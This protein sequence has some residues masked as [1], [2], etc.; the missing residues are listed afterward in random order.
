VEKRELAAGLESLPAQQ[1]RKPAE[2]Q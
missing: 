2:K 1:E